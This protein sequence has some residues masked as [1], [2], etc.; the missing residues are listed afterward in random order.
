M[1]GWIFA[2][3]SFKVCHVQKFD[4][5]GYFCLLAY[6]SDWGIE[7]SLAFPLFDCFYVFLLSPTT[8]LQLISHFII[9][10]FAA[11]FLIF[12]LDSL[13]LP[14]SLPLSSALSLPYNFLTVDKQVVFKKY[15]DW[16]MNDHWNINFLQNCL[17]SIQH[18]YSSEFSIDQCTSETSLFIWCEAGW[19]YF[20]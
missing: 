4:Q 18:T 19:G 7:L 14:T 5:I 12:F 1:I 2:S 20:L 8:F 3:M 6:F 16:E 17:L 11:S 15:Q 10:R 13:F 9:L